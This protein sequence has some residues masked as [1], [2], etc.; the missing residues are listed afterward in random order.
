[1]FLKLRAFLDPK[2]KRLLLS[3]CMQADCFYCKFQKMYLPELI[4]L[5]SSDSYDSNMKFLNF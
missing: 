3:L 5:A 4:S 1:M 2:V